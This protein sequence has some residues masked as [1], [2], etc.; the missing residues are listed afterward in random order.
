MTNTTAGAGRANPGC[1]TRGTTK[2]CEAPTHEVDHDAP[3]IFGTVAYVGCGKPA[4]WLVETSRG[5]EWHACES[6]AT[7]ALLYGSGE[8]TDA[9]GERGF[10]DEERGLVSA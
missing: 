4:T 3:R 8:V 1:S 7:D 5:T 6:H 2:R 10:L 9:D